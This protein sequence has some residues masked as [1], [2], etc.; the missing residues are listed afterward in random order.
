MRHFKHRTKLMILFFIT[1]II[2]MV[3]INM[4]G[5]RNTV[6]GMKSVEHNILVNKLEGDIL[7]AQ[8][9][10]EQYFG[11]LKEKDGKIVEKMDDQLIIDMK[12]L[13]NFQKI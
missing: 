2:P 6:S 4:L 11:E 9:Y 3:V 1:G 12:L 8:V 10:I 7:A 13:T 5:L